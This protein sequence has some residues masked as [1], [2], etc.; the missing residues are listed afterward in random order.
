M[1][2]REHK[3]WMESDTSALL[4]PQEQICVN[5]TNM[6]SLTQANSQGLVEAASVN[7]VTYCSRCG[8]F[9]KSPLRGH[10]HEICSL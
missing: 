8:E 10:K 2:R 4:N 7:G 5:L 3:T 6:L 9:N 1:I